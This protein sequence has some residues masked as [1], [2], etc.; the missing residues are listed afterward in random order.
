[1]RLSLLIARHLDWVQNNR[2]PR[3]FDV[4]QHFLKNFQKFVGDILVAEINR[5]MLENFYT[6]ARK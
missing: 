5:L 3:T 2:S 1:M 4:R 6:W